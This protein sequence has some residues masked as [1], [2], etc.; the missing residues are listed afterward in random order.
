M[1][2]V[3]YIDSDQAGWKRAAELGCGWMPT[4]PPEFAE[5][6][7]PPCV[8]LSGGKGQIV[9]I[10]ANEATLEEIERATAPLLAYEREA[11]AEQASLRDAGSRIS[12]RLRTGLARN[13]EYLD[14]PGFPSSPTAA[15]RDAEIRAIRAQVEALTRQANALI[16]LELAE[17][18]DTDDT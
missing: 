11:D 5:M 16:R 3:L 10:P 13:H 12:D 14:R 6:A 18:A 7:E 4:V 15:Q 17:L 2:R 8:I 9:V 1:A